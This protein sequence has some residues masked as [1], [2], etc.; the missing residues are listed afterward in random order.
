MRYSVIAARDGD[1]YHDEVFA[2]D[3]D[4]AFVAAREQLAEAWNMQDVLQ[5]ARSEGDETI[6]DADLDGFSVDPDPDPLEIVADVFRDARDAPTSF[7]DQRWLDGF[8]D[9]RRIIAER[10]SLRLG[11]LRSFDR[12][13]FLKAC[14][15]VEEA[16]EEELL[17]LADQKFNAQMLDGCETDDERNAELRHQT[18]GR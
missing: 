12:D 7:E 18:Q 17:R 2:D 4:A 11:G 5:R 16:S 6:F 8:E 13:R 10:L 14:D 3:Q 9:G 15:V 1:T